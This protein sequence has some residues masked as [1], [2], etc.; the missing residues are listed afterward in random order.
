MALAWLPLALVF[1]VE[2]TSPIW[3][4]LT[5]MLLLG[6]RLDRRRALAMGLGFAGV[7]VVLR[8]G[9]VALEPAIL[10]ALGAA[11]AFG[12]TNAM[13]KKLVQTDQPWGILF[14][15]CTSQTLLCLPFA[16]PLWMAPGT[17]DL[18]WIAAVAVT[19]LSAHYCLTRALGAAEAVVVLPMEFARL[20]VVAVIGLLAYGEPLD[21]WLF[22]GAAVIFAGIWLNVGTASRPPGG[23]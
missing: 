21:P 4:A 6:E 9:V 14:W 18:P 16:V 8:P 1:A 3:G 12:V 7:L 10:A 5:A 13:T 11:L 23:R 22:L 15:M 2:F 19:G 17:A 20:P